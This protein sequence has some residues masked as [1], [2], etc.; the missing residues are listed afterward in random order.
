MKIALMSVKQNGG[1][2]TSG[3][4][5]PGDDFCAEYVFGD[6]GDTSYRREHKCEVSEAEPPASV[7]GAG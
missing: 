7:M 2:S 5:T 1:R 3:V 4:N 6:L